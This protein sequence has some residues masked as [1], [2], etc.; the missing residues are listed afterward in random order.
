M[1]TGLRGRG[2]GAFEYI[3]LLAGVLL[4]VVLAII[5]LRGA[6]LPTAKNGIEGNVNAFA[7]VNCLPTRLSAAQNVLLVWQMDENTGSTLK[8]SSGNGNT[9][10]D[11]GGTWTQTGC[12]QG[13][14]LNFD[15]S[16]GAVTSG[17]P[18]SLSTGMTIEGWFSAEN[19][20]LDF[21][22]SLAA[23]PNAFD[24]AYDQLD[25]GPTNLITQIV[26]TAH[27]DSG[28][29]Q[30]ANWYTFTPGPHHLAATYDAATGRANVYADGHLIASG[31]S[32]N[33][34]LVNSAQALHVAGDAVI[35]GLGG[36]PLS[37]TV[38]QVV[39]FNR[40]LTANEIRNDAS[41]A[42]P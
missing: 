32:G 3:L 28:D 30:A 38:D 33:G 18:V 20:G 36:N 13:A 31:G 2:Q 42:L 15:G 24:F 21:V 27:T 9:G 17:Q 26:F 14:C 7:Q 35:P 22:G 8:D 16:S 6:I 4:I 11:A 37:G 10:T 19:V 40:A 29:R 34:N 12:R 25:D 5:I 1:R 41:C 23:K 39:L